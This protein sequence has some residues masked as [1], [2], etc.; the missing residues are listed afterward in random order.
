[1]P[2]PSNVDAHP[3]NPRLKK[4][5][6]GF[7]VAGYL[8]RTIGSG[9]T[10]GLVSKGIERASDA[11]RGYKRISSKGTITLNVGGEDQELPKTFLGKKIP[12]GKT[13]DSLTKEMQD[14]L[15]R[16]EALLHDIQNGTAPK[17]CSSQNMTDIMCYLQAK[18]QKQQ[19]FTEGSMHIP[20]EGGKIKAFLDTHPDAYMRKSSHIGEFQNQDSGVGVHRGIDVY[21]RTKNMDES[22]PNNRKALMYGSLNQSE[23]MKMSEER[24]WIKMEPHGAWAYGPNVNDPNGPKRAANSHD[25]KA[26]VGHAFSF[27]ETL[28]QGSAKGSRKERI[29]DDLKK[30]WKA[31]QKEARKEFNKEK[32]PSDELAAMIRDGEGLQ[33]A[34]GVRFINSYLESMKKNGELSPALQE[35]AEKMQEKLQKRYPDDI[36]LRIG[37]EA[38]LKTTDIRPRAKK[39]IPTPKVGQDQSQTQVKGIGSLGKEAANKAKKMKTH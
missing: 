12:P 4:V 36:D 11:I 37:N 9:L 33:T 21:G 39:D 3:E 22:L 10:L 24:L 6:T 1:M 34:R 23:G 17:Q 30:E 13:L 14:K 7:H 25:G 38:I 31:L 29:P 8:T 18:A 5:R 27:V 19:N 16:G 20:D 15:N 26:A 28:G 32:K 2:T 35:K